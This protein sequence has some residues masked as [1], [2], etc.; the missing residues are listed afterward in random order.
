MT[1]HAEVI[2]IAEGLDAVPETGADPALIQEAADALRRQSAEIERLRA[3]LAS[4]S[5]EHQRYGKTLIENSREVERLRDELA[6]A[7]QFLGEWKEL[8]KHSTGLAAELAAGAQ[9]A[10]IQEVYDWPEGATHYQPQ[11]KVFYKRVSACEWYVWSR[12]TDEPLHW[13][14]SPGTMDSAEWIVRAQ[15]E[16]DA[17]CITLPDGSCVGGLMAGKPPCMHDRP[18][19]AQPAP[20]APE[21]TDTM[22]LAFHCAL[23]AGRIS[24]QKV[25]EIKVGLRAALAAAPETPKRKPLTDKQLRE[26]LEGTN[27]MVRNAMHGPFWLEL[28][29]ACRAVEAAHGI[30]E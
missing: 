17:N 8:A 15:P 9:P 29:Q 18:S 7:Q 24:A 1:D 16:P 4:L 2:R 27:Y 19:G 12:I 20:S 13:S 22:A 14:Y 21:V 3:E 11:Q 26:V 23:T 25:D 6:Q 28:Q 5:E 10:P 30:K